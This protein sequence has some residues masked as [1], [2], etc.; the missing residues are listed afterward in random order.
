ME[1]RAGWRD[2]FTNE[3]REFSEGRTEDRRAGRRAVKRAGPRAAEKRG[4]GSRKKQLSGPP[5][6][7]A[8]FNVQP[9][10]PS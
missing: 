4:A 8:K 1:C 9:V 6:S 7:A 2:V 3:K 5:F 10:G